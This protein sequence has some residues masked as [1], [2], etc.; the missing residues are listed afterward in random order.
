M[1]PAPKRS[2]NVADR[3]RTIRRFI[4]DEDPASTILS[5]DRLP[6]PILPN[7][8]SELGYFADT[9]SLEESSRYARRVVTWGVFLIPLAIQ[10]SLILRLVVPYAE[11]YALIFGLAFAVG[12]TV[13]FGNRDPQAFARAA[14]IPAGAVLL[15]DAL[16]MLIESQHGADP[17]PRYLFGMIRYSLVPVALLVLLGP[18]GNLLDFTLQAQTAEPLYSADQHRITKQRFHP[19]AAALVRSGRD[20]KDG[21]RRAWL[22][23]TG[24]TILLAAVAYLIW[25]MVNNDGDANLW[26]IWI[27]NDAQGRT[28]IGKASDYG[29]GALAVNLGYLLASFLGLRF[30]LAMS[31]STLGQFL[32]YD[33]ESRG[34][35]GVY[36]PKE[37]LRN[38]RS[39]FLLYLAAL[40]FI[41]L[42]SSNLLLPGSGEEFKKMVADF[43]AVTVSIKP[44]SVPPTVAG[45]PALDLIDQIANAVSLTGQSATRG[46]AALFW[47]L[48]TSVLAST[49]TLCVVLILLLSLSTL[50]A[51]LADR[52]SGYVSPAAGG[53][54]ETNWQ[55]YVERLRD[56][57]F[58]ALDPIT[59]AH[60]RER[61]HL[62]LGTEPAANIPVLL[63]EKLL[64]EHVYI[65]GDSGS[66]KTSLGIM[67]VLKQLMRAPSSPFWSESLPEPAPVVVLDLK[68]DNALFQMTKEAAE[69]RGQQ[70]FF[71]TPEAKRASHH[72]NPFKDFDRESRSL[73]SFANLFLD[74]LSLNHGEG[75][76]R[77]YYTARN[78]QLLYTALEECKPTSFDELYSH[79][80]KKRGRV[81]DEAFELVASIQMLSSYK[82]LSDKRSGSAIPEDRIIH[83]QRLIEKGEVAYFWLPA[84]VE[85]ISVREIGKL[86]LFS[87][88]SAALTRQREGKETRTV[89]VV[90]DEF[91]RLAGE[92]FSIL[93]E[94]ARSFGIS[95]ILANQTLS[96]LNTPSKDLRP[97]IRTNT[98]TKFYFSI[99]EPEELANISALSGR[100]IVEMRS[101]SISR[102]GRGLIP[103]TTDTESYVEA[104][105]PRLSAQDIQRISDHPNE[106]LLH[107]S[108]GSGFTQFG[109]LPVRVRTEWPIPET[110]YTRL[111]RQPW[112][113][114]PDLPDDQQREGLSVEE[115]SIREREQV[116]TATK[117]KY[118]A[119][120][121][122]DM[123]GYFEM[124]RVPTPAPRRPRGGEDDIRSLYDDEDPT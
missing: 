40:A 94:Q 27:G 110:E 30:C 99:T 77:G 7:E 123:E 48:L 33:G 69:R 18:Q 78:R 106:F 25:W 39:N 4:I 43:S 67:P 112:P 36:Q 64:R 88:V 82:I 124:R 29:G 57:S 76:G 51:T 5:A 93:L 101:R 16:R 96:D 120:A 114:L 6:R 46:S 63:H 49:P 109:G 68:G 92:N 89:Y 22:M 66:G 45:E 20:T 91:Q 10:A 118:F 61:E 107:V 111:S 75:Y 50:Y 1:A 72:F 53:K 86:A 71:F 42:A 44:D 8:T 79:L 121:A 100:E 17:I 81:R 65:V 47:L 87:L 15:G 2:P 103:S 56:S 60:V 54:A 14:L 116:V 95:L 102:G 11:I 26:A 108:R 74:A 105:A 122:A 98:R 28:T 38:R 70:F 55:R 23:A 3:L 32:T 13:L 90:V 59:G 104:I 21:D 73:S 37:S 52:G 31:G 80:A 41:D 117:E 97:S 12:R 83:M 24:L 19:I 113:V 35:P 115:T 85:S 9:R 58:L 84:A 62:F 34:A 119:M